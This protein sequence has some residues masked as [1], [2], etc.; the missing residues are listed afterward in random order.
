MPKQPIRVHIFNQPY[1]IVAEDAREAEAIAHEIDELMNTIASRGGHGD[2][3]RVA[4][5]ACFHLA[6]RLRS[7]EKQLADVRSHSQ[8]ISGLLEE[9]LERS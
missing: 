4:V 3:A 1:T 6:D 2:A 8:R 9:T 7:A 5:L